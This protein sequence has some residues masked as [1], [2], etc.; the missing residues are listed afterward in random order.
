M[1]DIDV[2]KFSNM[3]IFESIQENLPDNARE[4][5]DVS[6]DL[7]FLWNYKESNL[8]VTN[9]RLAQSKSISKFQ[10]LVPLSTPNFVVSKVLVSFGGTFVC[11]S[12]PQGVSIIEMPL[13]WGADGLY[14]DG[15]SLVICQIF[16]L[17][18]HSANQLEVIQ[19]RW[20]PNSP[21]D[22]HLLILLSD[23]SIRV[24]DEGILKNHW[25]VG[26]I[27]SGVAVQKNLSY[28][29]CLGDTAVDF[30]IA[31]VRLRDG[32]I[33]EYN[34]TLDNNIES[35]NNTLNSFSL[36]TKTNSKLTEQQR[37]VEWP[38]VVLRGNGM[39]FVLN[40]ALNTE[41]P[42]FQGPLTMIPSQKENY[43]DDSCS[44]L[45][46]PTLPP[47]LVIAEN[48]G[49]LHH[50]LMI[51]TVNEELPFDGTNTILKNDYDL[52]VL[53]T[54]K[55]ELG[56]SDEKTKGIFVVVKS[57]Q[58]VSLNTMKLGYSIIPDTYN[59]TSTTNEPKFVEKKIPFDQYVKFLLNSG[60]TQPVLKLEKSNSPSH[61]QIFE[62]LMST[63]QIIRD[64]QFKRHD[65]VR[66]EITKR[67]KIL[68]FTKNQQR[69]DIT[70]LLESKEMIQEKA[71]KLADMHE[72][73]MERQQ[74]L[75]KRVQDVLRL[76]SLCLPSGNSSEK[77]FV[78]QIK[79]INIETN[80]LLQ[81]VKQIKAK[82]AIQR[83]QFEPW[84]NVTKNS[85]KALPPKQEETIQEILVDMT[86]Q[87]AK[88]TK[89][90][91]KTHSIVDA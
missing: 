14:Q 89:E 5:C 37:K 84:D 10:T 53:E 22:S 40:A 32:N 85:I 57:G 4:I 12:G 7:L 86:K 83:K 21:T 58:V 50:L 19:T 52:Y 20:H 47:T 41:K 44:I 65:Q 73:I 49:I 25:R 35:I 30:D 9:W 74:N 78:E 68:E 2:F 70:Q 51:D 62:L 60:V 33:H 8:L 3:K 88:L 66:Q 72:D 82:H 46:I 79:R 54:I 61:Q 80:K 6:E 16:H 69:E 17:Q 43:G 64:N 23:N 13:R 18:E 91:Q 81:D 59:F 55:L 75:Q 71:Y 36:T 77:E 11:I 28:L 29:R 48:S 45:V 87:I 15:K 76:A 42:R 27:P 39:V 34:E 63:A 38:I 56:L 67:V 26:P 90:V 1:T 24:F 31:P